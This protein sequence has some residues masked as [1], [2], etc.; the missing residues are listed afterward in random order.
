MEKTARSIL[1]AF[2]AFFLITTCVGFSLAQ[3]SRGVVSGTVTDQTGAV[4]SGADVELKKL[5]TNEVRT[6][7]TNDS[8]IYR[9]D[10]VDLGV[11]DVIMK[12]TG[13]KTTTI[14]RDMVQANQTA[15]IDAQM[16]VGTEQIVDTISAGAGEMLQTSEPVKGG[17]FNQLQVASLPSTNLNP[18]D[19]GRLLPGV[20]TASG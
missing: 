1:L 20:V 18:Y 15:A 5:A 9:F 11:Y 4:I 13:F 12:A 6:T 3:T 2:G 10:A 19:L 8:G 14:S 7:R 16:E 17:N